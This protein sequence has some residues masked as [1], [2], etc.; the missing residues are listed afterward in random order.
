MEEWMAAIR[1]N[2]SVLRTTEVSAIQQES[3]SDSVCK[4]DSFK[5]FGLSCFYLSHR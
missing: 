2:I 4:I 1:N 3:V 5:V